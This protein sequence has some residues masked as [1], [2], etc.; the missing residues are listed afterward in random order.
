[1]GKRWKKL[2]L[3][4]VLAL[5]FVSLLLLLLFKERILENIIKD[6]V[7]AESMGRYSIRFDEL[8]YRIKDNSILLLDFSLKGDT[9]KLAESRGTV[10]EVLIDSVQ[11][12]KVR[13]LKLYKK[14]FL[15]LS[16]IRISKPIIKI[17]KSDT[18][19]ANKPHEELQ[20]AFSKGMLKLFSRSLIG[21][22][23]ITN[24]QLE[25][26]NYSDDTIAAYSVR[27]F[28]VSLYNF[29]LG[30]SSLNRENKVFFS[31]DLDIGLHG[32][33]RNLHDHLLGIEYVRLS[34][35]SKSIHLEG[36]RFEPINTVQG[37]EISLHI[38]W[39]KFDGFDL[40]ALLY[41]EVIELD[42]ILILK[43]DLK[44]S[45]RKLDT[46]K[47]TIAFNNASLFDVF[48]KGVRRIAM[49]QLML[50]DVNLD[51]ENFNAGKY[52]NLNLESL[53]ISL[54]GVFLDSTVA[55][56]SRDSLVKGDLLISS[57]MAFY[58]NESGSVFK[59]GMFHYSLKNRRISMHGLHFTD[60]GERHDSL[61]LIIPSL[62]ITGVSL[63]NIMDGNYTGLK[64]LEIHNAEVY[65]VVQ[66]L[67]YSESV[68]V[69]IP[70]FSLNSLNAKNSSLHL[71][72]KDS[73]K[74]TA[75]LK[76]NLDFMLHHLKLDSNSQ[77]GFQRP[78][79]VK[80]SSG[81]FL[82]E[83][84]SKNNQ[85]RAKLLFDSREKSLLLKNFH[86]HSFAM[87][88]LQKK[89]VLRE[90]SFPSFEFTDFDY[91]KL[92]QNKQFE[93]ELASLRQPEIDLFVRK[94]QRTGNVTE[95]HKDL[96]RK[97]TTFLGLIRMRQFDIKDLE[98]N[99]ID[100]EAG[101]A[102]HRMARIDASFK[103]LVIDTVFDHR[104]T[105]LLF[106]EDFV[107]Q[108]N[109]LKLP[110]ELAD[111]ITIKNITLNKAARKVHLHD[112]RNLTAIEAGNRSKKMAPP[113]IYI[114]DIFINGVDFNN[115][116]LDKQLKVDSVLIPGSS[117]LMRH[118]EHNSKQ[119]EQP[120]SFAVPD[121]AA[122][123]EI[124]NI[125]VDSLK[126]EFHDDTTVPV[127]FSLSSHISGIAFDSSLVFVPFESPLPL[128]DIMIDLQKLIIAPDTNSRLL[129]DS[130]NLSFGS[131]D[132][133]A[134]GI[135]FYQRGKSELNKISMNSRGL[136]INGIDYQGFFEGEGLHCGNIDVDSCQVMI[137]SP[138]V[139][140]S[141]ASSL[142]AFHKPLHSIKVGEVRFQNIDL[143]MSSSKESKV[144]HLNNISGKVTNILFDSV[145]LH[146]QQKILFAEDIQLSKPEYTIISRDSMYTFSFD[147]VYLSTAEKSIRVD[148][149]Q[150]KPNY[151]KYEFSRKL[152]YQTD[153]MDV[154]FDGVSVEG[155]DFKRIIEDTYLYARHIRINNTNFEAFRD[156]R[157]PFP[158]WHTSPMPQDMIAS[159][160]FGLDVDTLFLKKAK[161]LYGEMVE[162][163]VEPGEISFNNMSVSLSNIT[164]D[165]LQI[166]IDPIMVMNV[167]GRIMDKG[168]LNARLMLKLN[169]PSDTFAF[170][171][172]LSKIDLSEFNSLSVNLF[173]V[174]IKSG[175]GAVDTL[176]IFGNKN[177]AIG[178]LYF[179]YR[180][181]KIRMINRQKGNRGGIGDGILTF[182]ANNILLKSNNRR[183]GRPVRVG[184]IFYQRDPQKSIFNYLWKGVLSGVESTLG[185]KTREQKKE[186]KEFKDKLNK[187][188]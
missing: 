124:D 18:S 20:L 6:A 46:Q 141:S 59:S 143:A 184:E 112:I 179:P 84:Y 63:W 34:T 61:R 186:V 67:P 185:Y 148:D 183:F 70:A 117:F 29:L 178:Q 33:E 45:S 89:V 11:L 159:L 127:K 100:N 95:L 163:S 175:D 137:D 76:G 152:G 123:Y 32:L 71:A 91:W 56:Q 93:I 116:Y 145:N 107:I 167:R 180:K 156:K 149:I 35:A 108:L 102:D 58:R 10:F 128:T 55:R 83:D 151:M 134:Y 109:N 8:D 126:F 51:I 144:A 139:S 79:Y 82:W 42:T 43:A 74:L 168:D 57:E 86:L 110:F 28:D 105:T 69:N 53:N 12:K 111:T 118:A 181:F 3:F 85:V 5:F 165:S 40:P 177:Y 174:E 188:D 49:Q 13:F 130:L 90:L 99:I 22:F 38:P 133:N 162:K 122:S 114:P 87:H 161:I 138:G 25:V 96:H 150:I 7:Y 147:D 23:N 27:S 52:E 125:L 136:D 187:I 88:E 182:L 171:A 31:D 103:H 158:E 54:S 120:P 68:A 129:L 146:D 92:L 115:F 50:K 172:S 60:P 1:M 166:L 66:K 65:K 142:E 36:I 154:F 135:S 21:L 19:F 16:E 160:G 132:L 64:E 73:V 41:D 26:F 173:G 140:A 81:E 131:K 157:L 153:R 170:N 121:I 4:S 164:N 94:G 37:A 104:E 119:L 48:P 169:H 77:L 101:I 97:L 106:A 72:F 113:G 14:R 2:L 15:D 17:F 80:L 155:V 98:V 30:D 78:R 39:A 24:G 62:K 47:S 44:I 75:R 176:N 9:S